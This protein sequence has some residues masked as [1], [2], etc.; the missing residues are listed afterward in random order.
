LAISIN[1]FNSIRGKE[2]IKGKITSKREREKR[3]REG[4]CSTEM[5]FTTVHIFYNF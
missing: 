2:K 1:Y 5:I 3:K 4:S